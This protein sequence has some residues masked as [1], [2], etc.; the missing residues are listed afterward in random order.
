MTDKY[1][2]I[3]GSGKQPEAEEPRTPKEDPNDLQSKQYLRFIDLLCEGEI[4]GL[5]NDAKSILID[6]VQLMNDDDEYNFGGVTYVERVGTSDQSVVPGFS[7]VENEISVGTQVT[8]ESGGITKNVSDTDVDDVRFTITVPQLMKIDIETGDRLRTSVSLAFDIRP[9]GGSWVTATT[10]TITGKC[11]STYARAVRVTDLANYG[12]GPWEIRVR[13]ITADSESTDL[14]ND[15]YWGSY[16]EIKNFKMIYPD[17]AYVAF[18]VD[19]QYFGQSMPTRQYLIKG[20]KIKIPDNYDPVA[21]TYT[22]VWTGTFTTA[23][24]NNP[25][26]VLYDLLTN[27]RYG[28]GIDEDKVD[29]W[30]LYTIGAYCDTD[31]DDGFGAQEPRFTFNGVIKSRTDAIQAVN[32][33]AS[34]FMVMPYWS[35]GYA[36]F[37]QDSPKDPVKLFSSANVIDGNFEYSGTSKAARHTVAYITWNDPDDFYYPKVEVVQYDEWVDRYGWNPVE[38]VAV[39]CTSRGQAV[40]HGKWILDSELYQTQTV[41]FGAGWY[42][43]DLL[44]GQIIEIADPH[45]AQA[46]MGGFV[47]SG[48]VSAV[49]LDSEV[50][51]EA[52][53]TY[54]AKFVSA[55]GT[56]IS[57]TVSNSP[58]TTDTLTFSPWLSEAPLPNAAWQITA[59]N[60]AP[61][62]WQVISVKEKGIGKYD[63]IALQYDEN[64]FARVEEGIYFDAPPTYNIPV[65]KL[66]PPTNIDAEEY[67]FQDGQNPNFGC[68]ISW[69]HSP[70]ARRYYYQIQARN[71]TLGETWIARGETNDNSFDLRPVVSGVWDFRVRAVG[72]A[73]VSEWLTLSSFTIYADPTPLPDITGLQVK[74]GGDEWS[75]K[76][77]PIEWDSVSGTVYRFKDYVVEVRDNNTNNL[78]RTAY[79]TNNEYTYL[80]AYNE[81]DNDQYSNA[82]QRDLKFSVWARDVYLKT[83]VN[84]AVLVATNPQPDYTG[85]VPTA[86]GIFN[87]VIVDWSNI[88]GGDNDLV[89]FDIYLEDVDPPTTVVATVDAETTQW[90]QTELNPYTLYYARVLPYD[91][92]GVGIISESSTGVE[93]RLLDATK[94]NMELSGRITFSD[95]FGSPEDWLTALY[96]KKLSE[97]AIVYTIVSGTTSGTGFGDTLSGTTLSGLNW[98]QYYFPIEAYIDEVLVYPGSGTNVP[99]FVGV[100]SDGETWEYFGSDGNDDAIF[101]EGEMISYGTNISGAY[102]N[103]VFLEESK[104][105]HFG[106]PNKVVMKYAR[107]Y[108]TCY[109][110]TV[111]YNEIEFT[112][113]VMAERLIGDEVMANYASLG[114]ATAG[115]IQSAN[116]S[117]GTGA[118]WNLNN[119]LFYLGGV[120]DPKFSYTG[121]NLTINIDDEASIN[122]EEGA[123]FTAGN[124]N[125]MIDTGDIS[126][127]H[128][129]IIVGQDGAIV[130]GAI[131]TGKSYILIDNGQVKSYNWYLNEWKVID[132]LTKTVGGTVNNN[133]LV[134][135]GWFPTQPVVQV[136]PK[137]MVTYNPTY[138][139]QKQYMDYDVEN[140]EQNIYT[141][142]WTFTPVARLIIGAAMYHT[143]L[144]DEDIDDTML[145][146]PTET[147]G[148]DD[149]LWIPYNTQKLSFSIDTLCY[150]TTETINKYYRLQLQCKL[151]ADGRDYPSGA[152]NYF[153]IVLPANTYTYNFTLTFTSLYDPDD[154]YWD[155]VPGGYSDWTDYFTT[156]QSGTRSFYLTGTILPISELFYYE[157]TAL[158]T[159]GVVVNT[160]ATWDAC[161]NAA[162]GTSYDDYTGNL[163]V[164]IAA[165]D[166]DLGGSD[167]YKIARTF[168]SFNLSSIAVPA[169]YSVRFDRIEIVTRGDTN[170]DSSV[171]VYRGKQSGYISN[172]DFDSYTGNALSDAE[173]WSVGENTIVLN[174][175]GESYL[176]SVLYSTY[177]QTYTEPRPDGA[178][179]RAWG[180]VSTSLN[181]Q[182][183]LAG[184]FSSGAM[185]RSTDGG[186]NWSSITTLTG[187]ANWYDCN[188]SDD[189]VYMLAVRGNGLY[190]Y[191]TNSGID[192]TT[193][194]GTINAYSCDV[195]ADG[196][197]MAIAGGYGATATGVAVSTD[198]GATWSYYAPEGTETYPWFNSIDIDD[199]GSFMITCGA[200]IGSVGRV[201]TSSDYGANWDEVDP[202]GDSAE[203]DWMC[204]A[205]ANNGSKMLAATSDRLYLYDGDAWNEIYPP[206]GSPANKDWYDLVISEDGTKMFAAVYGG[207]VYQSVD[208]GSTWTT[209]GL[210]SA[211]FWNI[212]C[213]RDATYL[214]TAANTGRI[215]KGTFTYATDNIARFCLREYENDVLNTASGINNNGMYFSED[216]DSTKRPLI[217]LYYYLDED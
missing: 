210:S 115:I 195:S 128:A 162:A 177:S 127:S 27:T 112:D 4:S 209:L 158:E 42:A 82:P 122:L 189:G 140:L 163:P 97:E 22:G 104:T 165:G 191:S 139:G 155:A 31:V 119:D 160:A 196:R 12:A 136:S 46:R 186:V 108:F 179:D 64:K 62:K 59:S 100:S 23:Y 193:Y 134:N 89:K 87:G 93:A 125:I 175:D 1:K 123:K 20:L 29:K 156:A 99:G 6:E 170:D 69:E 47:V 48:T 203:H 118:Y 13:R 10:T 184:K 201:Y 124:G 132:G 71:N 213:S 143:D 215:R 192:W 76:D 197:V 159:D 138:S 28:L 63:I 19:A 40:R 200:T 204:C 153:N 133:T 214:V 107:W 86:L 58:E 35:S 147:A 211:N 174:D 53:E 188:M 78:L 39:G 190:Q 15:T 161:R 21:R 109:S 52:G 36:T 55:S 75:G 176:S 50:E 167:E 43:A 103:P 38:S 199:D 11:T 3:E 101:Q 94:V 126:E 212:E 148:V 121:A 106:L 18:E 151:H 14:V 198:Y 130:N 146:F 205:T 157:A 5:I 98:I 182:I 206:G 216:T 26:W 9:D 117:S 178:A 81:I 173:G 66:Q 144:D 68:L 2:Y 114:V 72:V 116:L 137:Y 181:G 54:D 152:G 166:T 83:S 113:A 7:K 84:A 150:K 131:Q 16:T 77:C 185:Y 70:D 207:S 180:C 183:M 41:A 85:L 92:F 49:I 194:T 110:G 8:E 164:A 34:N 208:S 44:P 56:I 25:A 102:N 17:T 95:S 91:A 149:K 217:K 80:F 142:D 60:L 111:I 172:S 88:V 74:G 90:V 61:R 129:R 154:G 145:Y 57:G 65:G 73:Q 37:S 135:L 169:G 96:D 45:Y 120:S 171:V 30:T 105:N 32:Y 51:I 33:I 79:P 168:L 187:S 202:V 67:T 141:G 24:S